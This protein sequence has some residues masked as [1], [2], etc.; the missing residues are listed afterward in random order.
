M[1]RS[2]EEGGRRCNHHNPYGIHKR[3]L[4]A[5]KQY[6]E[7]RLQDKSLTKTQREKS[8][9]AYK[10]AV[11]GINDLN[12][13]KAELGFVKPYVMNLTKAT[14][15]VLD[16]LEAD[17]FKPYIVGGSV[18][19]ALMGYDSKDI[20][21]EVYGGEPDLVANSLRKIG[22]V[23]EVGK[24]F[25]VLKIAIGKE[26]FDISLPR[27]DSKTGDGHTDFEVQVDPDLS[28]E[29]AT[30]RRDYTINALMYSHKLGFIIDKHKGLK[31][32]E[33]KHLRHVSDA[34]DED[35]LRVL[36]GVQMASRFGM[37]LHPDT[38]EKA[39]SLKSGFNNLAVERVQI[40][41]EKLYSKGKSP[42]KA[43][44]LLKET[45]WEDNFAGLKEANTPAL[46][47]QVK[48]MQK[49]IDN[50]TVP[51]DR[52]DMFL[53]ATIAN[54]LSDKDR[55]TFLSTTTIG[56]NVKNAA[57]QLAVMKPPRK[58]GKASLR[59]WAFDM[60]RQLTIR[61]W[62][63][64]EKA[65][66]DKDAA[67]RILKKAEKLGV[68][69]GREPDMIDG[70]DIMAHFSDRKPGPWMAET[71]KKVREAQYSDQFRTRETGLEWIKK[72]L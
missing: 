15:R 9:K 33:N 55:L 5:Q 7:H 22:K 62:T 25:G 64:F 49:L 68:A 29:E 14:E 53:S 16:Q 40:E 67:N 72:N 21:I 11:E 19:D 50:G 43:L 69:D 24:S 44:K 30:A 42:V 65:V 51:A 60:P 56:S 46:H 27:I 23:D 41:F 37:S 3:N 61:D 31:D 48:K 38:I 36:R 13:E 59:K 18:R 28:L 39:Q 63:T 17:G 6:H 47:R 52:R 4:Q 1:C 58:Q 71:V 20:D 35:P 66:G 8:L 45:G 34:F 12:T 70:L 57:A 2:N 10:K 26:D 32:L 54:K